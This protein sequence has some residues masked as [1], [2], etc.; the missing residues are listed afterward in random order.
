MAQDDTAAVSEDSALRAEAVAHA[1]EGLLDDDAELFDVDCGADGCRVET[2]H[3]TPEAYAAFTR[4]FAPASPEQAG[5]PG[6]H[7]G[8]A[9]DFTTLPSGAASAD[10]TAVTSVAFLSPPHQP[11]AQD[12]ESDDNLDEGVGDVVDLPDGAL[13]GTGIDSEVPGPR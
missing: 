2:R 1:I 10:G 13:G 4:K 5:R 12:L 3:T 9:V 8:E 7:W 6:S 11:P